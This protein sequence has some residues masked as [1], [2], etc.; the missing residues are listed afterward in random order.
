[1]IYIEEPALR[2]SAKQKLYVMFNFIWAK[3]TVYFDENTGSSVNNKTVYYNRTYGTLPTSKT[4]HTFNG[5]FTDETWGTSY[6]R[7]HM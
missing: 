2:S 6:R 7:N 3:M 1:M 4:G 5:W